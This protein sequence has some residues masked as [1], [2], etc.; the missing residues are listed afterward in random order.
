MWTEQLGA[1]LLLSGIQT[2]E[3]ESW[4]EKSS[5]QH[6]GATCRL[7]THPTPTLFLPCFISFRHLPGG[8]RDL[9]G[10]TPIVQGTH[11]APVPRGKQ[12]RQ[13]RSLPPRWWQTSRGQGEV[14]WCRAGDKDQGLCFQD[15]S[16]ESE[17][18]QSSAQHRRIHFRVRELG[19]GG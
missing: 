7:S 1:K 14:D 6:T 3:V 19:C 2:T 12:Q 5:R 11:P 13:G 8:P 4:K 15:H 10:T 17:G 18:F 16:L 9:L